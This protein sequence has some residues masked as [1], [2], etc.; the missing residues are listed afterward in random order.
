V[1]FCDFGRHRLSRKQGLNSIPRILGFHCSLVGETRIVE[2]AFVMEVAIR[3]ENENV[4]GCEASI[5]VMFQE[6]VRTVRVWQAG[7]G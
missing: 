7:G 3:V 1:W 4:R 2:L 6:V 5:G